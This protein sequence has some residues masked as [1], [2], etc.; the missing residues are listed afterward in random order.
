[1]WQCMLFAH[2]SD[3]LAIHINMVH[4]VWHIA[5]LLGA[6]SV[7]Q[8]V[9][10]SGLRNANDARC[11]LAQNFQTALENTNA[12]LGEMFWL[13]QKGKV[14]NSGNKRCPTCSR[15]NACCM[16][17]VNDPCRTFHLWPVETQPRFIEIRTRQ[18]QRV[19]GNGR[20]VW[21][22]WCCLVTPCDPK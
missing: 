6:E 8:A 5:Q 4:A 14:V 2:R 10:E 16:H 13:V 11:S 17:E 9:I 18:R 15:N 12:P 21:L 22:E 19:H 20:A 7:F 1:M 3:L